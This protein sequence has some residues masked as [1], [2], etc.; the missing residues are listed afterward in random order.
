MKRREWL[1]RAITF[2]LIAVT[3][4]YTLWTD[5]RLNADQKQLAATQTKLNEVVGRNDDL[6]KQFA[7]LDQRSRARYRRSTARLSYTINGV[8]DW[9][10]NHFQ[11]GLAE[12]LHGLDRI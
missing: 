1:G 4:A 5:H 12:Q 8:A 7:F 10:A 9:S 6:K 3:Y 2:V 11:P